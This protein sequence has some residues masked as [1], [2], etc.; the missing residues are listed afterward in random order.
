VTD[1]QYQGVSPATVSFYSRNWSH[2]VRDPGVETV[3]D[4]TPGVIRSWLLAHQGVTPT[5]RRCRPSVSGS[6]AWAAPHT[7]SVE[8]IRAGGDAFSLQG[9]LGHS[10]LDMT[11]RYVNL[12]DTDLRAVH[13]RFAP[14]DS[15]I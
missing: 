5:R 12:A 4:L 14:A 2:F 13:R 8:F 6:A 1:K 9:L 11:R 15:W 3:A 7:F 10:T